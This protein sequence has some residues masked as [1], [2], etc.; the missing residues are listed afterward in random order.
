[1]QRSLEAL[2]TPD[3][4]RALKFLNEGAEA[5]PHDAEFLNHLG[6]V[7]WELNN[8]E[9]A[10]DA[11]LG[12]M[13][14]ALAVA[15]ADDEAGGEVDW[16]DSA[17]QDYL[18]AM[19]GRALCL[20]RLESYDEAL[21]LFDAL[22]KMSAVD[23]AGCRY[24]AGEIRHLRG[25]FVAAIEDYRMGPVEPASLYNLGLA[26]F[27]NGDTE[28]AA[29]T[30]IRAFVSNIHV[31]H[32]F[33]GRDVAVASCVPGYLGGRDYALDFV[34]ACGPLWGGCEEAVDFMETCYD[35][36]LV[37]DY[38]VQCRADGGESMLENA[39]IDRGQANWLQVLTDETSVEGLAETVMKRLYS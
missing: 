23:Y 21:V 22:A 24:M 17:N 20:C 16:R 19:E 39:S 18:R 37:Q 9:L 13:S 25:D 15:G 31:F 26:Q 30:F 5:F 27:Q 7:H 32:V 11:Y 38:L 4:E 3:Y 2:A 14:A 6:L 8:F 10:A 35:H 1:L 36:P 12:A 28:S 34:R 33:C 29:A